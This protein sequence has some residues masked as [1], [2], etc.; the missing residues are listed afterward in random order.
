RARVVIVSPN[1]LMLA[2]QTMQAIMKDARMRDEAGLIQREV[3]LLTADVNRLRERVL[4]MQRHYGQLGE[5][6]EKIL[7]SSDKIASR[8]RKIEALEFDAPHRALD[9]A[10]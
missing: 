1:M 10:E 6:V 7:T 4:D 8:G 2:V 3:A 5:D 9:A